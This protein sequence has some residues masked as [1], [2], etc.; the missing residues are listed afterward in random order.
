VE[1]VLMAEPKL[2]REASL[3]SIDDLADRLV[4]AWRSVNPAK[5]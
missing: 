1:T 5:N 2:L 4:A 3:A